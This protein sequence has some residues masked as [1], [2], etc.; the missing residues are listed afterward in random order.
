[1]NVK[2]LAVLGTEA[3]HIMLFTAPGRLSVPAL[4]SQLT[5]DWENCFKSMPQ[6]LPLH[7]ADTNSPPRRAVMSSEFIMLRM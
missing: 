1:M 4:P 7:N 6:F 5:Y 2:E 3:V